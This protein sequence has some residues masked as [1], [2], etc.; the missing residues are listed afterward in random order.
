MWF[1]PHVEVWFIGCLN[2]ICRLTVAYCKLHVIE[3][4]VIDVVNWPV[5]AAF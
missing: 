1:Y 2:S 3:S 4:A 5:D